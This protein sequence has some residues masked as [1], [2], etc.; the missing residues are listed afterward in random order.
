MTLCC[1]LWSDGVEKE[2][3]QV[4]SDSFAGEFNDTDIVSAFPLLFGASAKIHAWHHACQRDG[5]I[6][7]EIL[8][9][10]DP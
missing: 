9:A 3:E 2:K 8:F 1:S 5:L 7:T 10:R 6:E 4:T